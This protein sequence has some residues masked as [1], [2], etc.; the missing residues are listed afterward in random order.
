MARRNVRAKI[1]SLLIPIVGK[2]RRLRWDLAGLTDRRAFV[3]VCATSDEKDV[4]SLGLI[5]AQ[6]IVPLLDK[7][8][9]VL[10]I[11]CGVGRVE[12]YLW[13]YC[14]FIHSV[15]VS[16]RMISVARKRLEGIK[17]VSFFRM[18]ATDLRTFKDESY[19]LCFSFHCL[20]HME[21]EDA[22]LALREIF[23][24]LRTGGIA[25]VHV[26]DFGSQTY[27][28]LFKQQNHWN[29]RSRVRG[30]TI[31]EISKILRDVG[32]NIIREEHVCLNPYVQPVEQGRDIIL[33][34]RK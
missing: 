12:K 26:P 7:S 15:D 31:P 14:R 27:F 21:K 3:S 24:V 25:Y 17:N 23:R 2:S 1:K 33:T 9:T 28:L 29:D 16:D 10:D 34:L 20:Q 32:F 18:S 30:Y 5:D 4:D 22:Y 19:D 6:R 11:G 8:S 13:P